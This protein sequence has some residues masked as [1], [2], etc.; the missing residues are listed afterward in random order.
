MTA[1]LRQVNAALYGLGFQGFLSGKSFE[2]RR[3]G[4][5]VSTEHGPMAAPV[6][7]ETHIGKCPATDKIAGLIRDP[8]M[9]RIGSSAL[10]PGPVL[11]AFAVAGI[12]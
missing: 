1:E 2:R 12:P 8:S 10:Q 6:C 3:R 11:I 7:V 4:F 9:R 5:R